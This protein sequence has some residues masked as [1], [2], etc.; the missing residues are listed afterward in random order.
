M[1][2]LA[3]FMALILSFGIYMVSQNTDTLEEH[4]Y[5]EQGLDF[6]SVYERKQNLQKYQAKPEIIV[7]TD[8]ML[9]RFV[10]EANHG[11]LLLRRPSDGAQ[12]TK[13]P[14]SF[15]GKEYR[16]PITAFSRGAWEVRIAWE[17]DGVP[18]LYEQRI[19][20]D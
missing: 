11:K 16:L 3:F 6:D 9:V 10:H 20:L 12:D 8:T 14:F 5:Y 2:A 18:Y 15:E 1:I 17:A 4:D 13:I 19:F 7:N